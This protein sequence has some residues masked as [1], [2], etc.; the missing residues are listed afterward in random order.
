[1]K[2]RVYTDKPRAIL[3][4]EELVQPML[5]DLNTASWLARLGK[6][7]YADPDKF[8]EWKA[9]RERDHS[10]AIKQVEVSK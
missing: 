7:H 6:T 9:R 8:R 3:V 2:I 10:R 4:P 5:D 1:V